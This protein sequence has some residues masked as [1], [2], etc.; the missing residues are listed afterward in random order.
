MKIIK[1]KIYLML[2]VKIVLT[3][4]SKLSIEEGLPIYNKV[5]QQLLDNLKEIKKV[6]DEQKEEELVEV[7]KSK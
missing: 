2:L 7:K 3:V 1:F 6:Q 4:L 5:Y